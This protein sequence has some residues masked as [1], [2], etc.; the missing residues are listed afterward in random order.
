MSKFLDDLDE[1]MM[2]YRCAHQK[3]YNVFEWREITD[4]L[5]ATCGKNKWYADRNEI[6]F[7]REKHLVLFML[8]WL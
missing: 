5:D 7:A 4:W 6:C 3:V 8:R 1:L 2:P